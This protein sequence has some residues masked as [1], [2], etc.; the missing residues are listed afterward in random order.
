MAKKYHPYIVK[1][2]GEKMKIINDVKSKLEG[3]L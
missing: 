2:S 3:I 1:D